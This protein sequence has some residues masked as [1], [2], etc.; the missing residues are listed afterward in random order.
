MPLRFRLR[1]RPAGCCDHIRGAVS[2][3]ARSISRL[4]RG[5][6]VDEERLTATGDPFVDLF[7]R[8]TALTRHLF[9]GHRR[10]LL[11]ILVISARNF[12]VQDVRASA[13][14][15][16]SG[17]EHRQRPHLRLIRYPTPTLPVR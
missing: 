1:T 2:A 10:E 9:D 4:G 8:L 16:P 7:L 12:R 15:S 6:F 17:K 11:G 14:D 13:Q 3:S 5:I